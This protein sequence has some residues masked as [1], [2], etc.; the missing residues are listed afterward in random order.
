M[1]QNTVRHQIFLVYPTRQCPPSFP[2]LHDNLFAPDSL[3]SLSLSDVFLGS[4]L[5]LSR[6]T[7]AAC[8]DDQS[9]GL[10]FVGRKHPELPSSRSP[11]AVTQMGSFPQGGSRPRAPHLKGQLSSRVL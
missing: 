1:P 3:D 5:P 11:Q 4:D 6:K 9:L 8:H 10:S 7:S 2:A